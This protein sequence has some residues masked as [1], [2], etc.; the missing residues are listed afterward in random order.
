MKIEIVTMAALL[1]AMLAV[2]SQASAPRER[3]PQPAASLLLAQARGDAS[4]KLDGRNVPQGTTYCDQG[5]L[6][7]CSARGGWEKTGK[8]C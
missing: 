1:A 8:S 4:C 5:S 3:T 7:R 2:P 6:M